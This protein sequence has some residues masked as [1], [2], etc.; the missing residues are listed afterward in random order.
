MADQTP[1]PGMPRW[2]KILG[3]VAIIVVAHLVVVRFV[4]GGA[5]LHSGHRPSAEDAPMTAPADGR[6]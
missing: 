5:S 6:R 3:I 4:L 1:H 2:V